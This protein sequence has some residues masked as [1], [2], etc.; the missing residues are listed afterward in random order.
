[1]N[2]QV[3]ILATVVVAISPLS[4]LSLHAQ[5]MASQFDIATDGTGQSSASSPATPSVREPWS[6]PKVDIFLGYSYLRAVP[7]LANGNRLVDMNGGSASIAFD[8]SRYFGIVADFGGYDDT[9]LRLGGPGANPPSVVDS[10]GSAFT[11]LFGPGSLSQP[12]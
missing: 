7:E 1:M 2:L 11:Y 3:R 9:Q 8:L 10:G 6:T 5:R 4:M 12:Q